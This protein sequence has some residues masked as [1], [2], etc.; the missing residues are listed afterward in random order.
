MKMTG[1]YIKTMSNK[2]RLTKKTDWEARLHKFIEANHLK[3][4]TWG[5]WDCCKFADACIKEMACHN[6]SLIPKELT[7]TNEEE[8]LA[9]ISSYGGT[10]G[11][12]IDKAAKAKDLKQIH[13]NYLQTGDL[14]IFEGDDGEDSELVGITINGTLLAPSDEG[15]AA[16]D[17]DKALRG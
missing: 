3:P 8:A 1:I 6:W 11:K 10:L 16:K 5:S 7:W 12:S 13:K 17:I 4:F 9:A 14:V 15:I 2:D